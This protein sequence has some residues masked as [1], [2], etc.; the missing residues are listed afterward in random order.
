[1][2]CVICSLLL[3]ETN[4][5][6]LQD[7]LE[8]R[9]QTQ[10]E[11]ESKPRTHDTRGSTELEIKTVYNKSESNGTIDCNQFNSEKITSVEGKINKMEPANRTMTT[12]DSL[13]ETNLLINE[14]RLKGA[15]H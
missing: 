11:N 13:S 9:H 4:G 15:Y 12:D 3:D 7:T 8:L 1:M 5:T 2:V 14:K 10:T 6:P